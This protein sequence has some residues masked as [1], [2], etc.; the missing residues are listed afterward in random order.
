MT[1]MKKREQMTPA[2]HQAE[3]DV[4]KLRDDR[5]RITAQIERIKNEGMTDLAG[6]AAISAS[7]NNR[8]IAQIAELNDSGGTQEP[9]K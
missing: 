2:D 6:L 7:I 1:E 3:V 5:A 9:P 8:M 4:K